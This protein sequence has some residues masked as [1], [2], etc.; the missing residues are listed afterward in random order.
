LTTVYFLSDYGLGDEFVGVVHA[1]IARLAPGV[2]IVDLAHEVPAFDV[3]AGAGA[4]VR[5]LPYLGRGVVLAV[6]DPGV[7]SARRPIAVRVASAGGPTWFVGP[8]NGVLG[9]ALADAGGPEESVVLDR[10][11]LPA[12]RPAGAIREP[13]AE[14]PGIAVTFDGRDV[15]AP[16]TA[17]LC[18]GSALGDLGRAID[19]D[20]LV[21][22]AEV[23][24]AVAVESGGGWTM[25]TEV[26]WVDH[27]G[28]A[29]LT[30]TATPADLSGEP[31]AQ[32]TVTAA[33]RVSTVR[34][35][36]AFADLADGEPGLLV[37]GSGHLALVAFRSSA[38]K[39]LG[40]RPGTTV[41]VRW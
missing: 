4:L 41:E 27:F 8:D 1:V 12:A 33:G 10:S 21:S 25:T 15:F 2:R 5:A 34:C 36:N 11:R 16:A 22:L 24:S 9:W 18:N 37:D 20:E 6:V 31:V 26:T 40:V 19:P 38:A 3:R 7:G 35:V 13:V 23:P 39:E 30:A 14:E 29:S 32:V 28:N 17:A